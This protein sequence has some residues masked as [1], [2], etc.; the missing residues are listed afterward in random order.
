MCAYVCLCVYV[1]YVCVCVCVCVCKKS[2]ALEDGRNK[3]SNPAS[4][5]FNTFLP[6]IVIQRSHIRF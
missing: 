1:L 6:S 4:H 5:S 2:R 3:N